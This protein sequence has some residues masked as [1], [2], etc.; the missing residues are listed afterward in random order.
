[1]ITLATKD[2]SPG[3]KGLEQHICKLIPNPQS[4]WRLTSKQKEALIK[5]KHNTL[6]ILLNNST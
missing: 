5:I 1:M 3:K 6:I 2:F 4:T